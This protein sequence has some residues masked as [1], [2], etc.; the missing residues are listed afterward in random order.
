M[1]ALIV[2]GGWDGHTPKPVSEIVEKELKAAGFQVERHDTLDA[3]NDAAKVASMDVVIPIWTMGQMS[4]EQ[5]GSLNAAVRAGTGVAGLHGGAGDA[6]RGNLEY[7]W[8]I[9]GQFVGH[10]HVGKYEVF[11]TDTQH[12]ITVG[13]PTVFEYESEQYYMIV[14]PGINVLAN[15]I[16]NYDGH[17]IVH[18][19]MWTKSW[20]KGRVFYTA[21]GHCD[22]EFGKFPQVHAMTIKGLIWAAQGKALA[23]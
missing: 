14:D 16:Y 3:L 5:W 7:Q 12:P 21:L 15:T 4:G 22:A 13:A 19:V 23:K 6:F 17:K 11:L 10:P 1:K 2:Y 8:M 9:G 18:P 20:G